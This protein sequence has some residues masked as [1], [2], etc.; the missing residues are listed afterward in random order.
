MYRGRHRRERQR[1]RW[2][3]VALYAAGPTGA[4]FLALMTFLGM[5]GETTPVVHEAPRP[6]RTQ[7]DRPESSQAAPVEV[8]ADRLGSPVNR[9]VPAARQE[10]MIV[11]RIPAP[12]PTPAAAPAPPPPPALAPVE[13]PK[14]AATP[15]TP[16]PAV[17][18]VSD[19]PSKQEEASEEIGPEPTRVPEKTQKP[20]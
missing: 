8:Q 6:P 3:S 9:P 4:A 17:Q 11:E 19:A 1:S 5:G 18:A 15:I 12:P 20:G 7:A 10:P 13:P 16:P 14:I 2:Q